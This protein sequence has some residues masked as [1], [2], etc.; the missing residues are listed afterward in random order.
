MDETTV[1]WL[2]VFAFMS[3]CFIGAFLLRL[4]MDA[5]RSM[6]CADKHMQYE[7]VMAACRANGLAPPDP[8]RHDGKPDDYPCG[9]YFHEDISVFD[10]TPYQRR[11]RWAGQA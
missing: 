2:I 9:G 1:A 7:R 11:R 6:R 3:G 5:K 8:P 10:L 4:Y